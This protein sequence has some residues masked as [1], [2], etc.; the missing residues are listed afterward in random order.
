MSDIEH[1]GRIVEA[2]VTT[3]AP[4]ERVW[5]AWTDPN[6]FVEWFADEMQGEYREGGEVIWVFKR[7]DMTI[8]YKV[9]HLENGRR[10]VLGP[11][12][13]E[14]PFLLDV[15]ITPRKGGTSVRL[16]NSGFSEASDFD[17]ELR[18]VESGWLMTLGI[19]KYYVEEHFGEKRTM[20]FA[21]REARYDYDELFSYY[22]D[23]DK[24][25]KWLTVEGEIHR[26]GAPVHLVLRD[27]RQVT[28]RV[29]VLTPREIA[30]S[31]DE[32]KGGLELKAFS[33][34]PDKRAVC[35]RGW[36]WGWSGDEAQVLEQSMESALERLV[37]ALQP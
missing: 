11:R 31:W 34:A 35:I 29:L 13:S 6:R 33:L 7:F 10:L 16:L 1:G 23:R 4:P 15:S 12:D 26:E 20:F 2:E 14:S 36:G 5:E 27:G 19:L 22:R 28:G 24:L 21:V 37:A 8:P 25:S 17:D 30:L 32:I 9:I 18:S 3:A